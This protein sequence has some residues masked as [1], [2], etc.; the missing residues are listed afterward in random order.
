MRLFSQ[1]K[2]GCFAWNLLH[3]AGALAFNTKETRP[4]VM[5][6]TGLEKEHSAGFAFIIAGKKSAEASRLFLSLST[7]FLCSFVFPFHDHRKKKI[8][9]YGTFLLLN[10]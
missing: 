10:N 8:R 3:G 6:W 2:K 9:L 7:V 1:Q 5:N 4:G